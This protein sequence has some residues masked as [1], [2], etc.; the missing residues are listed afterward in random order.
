[1]GGS[2]IRGLRKSWRSIIVCR[3]IPGS[4]R[5]ITNT[6]PIRAT[7]EIEGLRRW[8]LRVYT[9]NF[10]HLQLMVRHDEYLRQYPVLSPLPP[11]NRRYQPRYHPCSNTWCRAYRVPSGFSD[12]LAIQ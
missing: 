4:S 7:T 6:S 11:P 5:W 1:M 10:E 9:R 2:L 8:S 3:Y 12:Q